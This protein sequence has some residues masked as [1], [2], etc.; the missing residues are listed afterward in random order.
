[1]IM[2]PASR[3]LCTPMVGAAM[4]LALQPIEADA[5]GQPTV[6]ARANL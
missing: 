6:A 2:M 4:V 3:I 1:M 5:Q